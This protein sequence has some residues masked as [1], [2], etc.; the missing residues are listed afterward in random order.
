MQHFTDL[1]THAK[2]I[3]ALNKALQ[4]ILPTPLRG[5]KVVRVHEEVALVLVD[6]AA[7]LQFAKATD[8]RAY[9]LECAGEVE[10]RSVE[11]EVKRS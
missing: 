10:I 2:Y 9:L 7:Q 8:I 4:K 6:N 3:N 5:I 1:V 11:Y